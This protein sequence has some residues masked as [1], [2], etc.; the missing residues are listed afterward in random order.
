MTVQSKKI[1]KKFCFKISLVYYASILFAN[2]M[3]MFIPMATVTF[4]TVNE[5]SMIKWIAFTDEN[6]WLINFIT[7]LCFVIPSGIC[8]KD[9]FSILFAKKDD[10][11]AKK[12]INLPLRFS[13]LGAF[14][15][16]LTF[17]AELIVLFYV[18]HVLSIKIFYIIVN[19]LLFLAL[20]GIFS[21]IVS[22]L[23]LATV[24][25]ATVLPKLF[26]KGEV[27]KIPGVKNL[28]LT[29]MFVVLYISICF[30]PIVYLL[31]AYISEHLNYGIKITSDTIVMSFVLLF[32]GLALTVV[33]MKLFTIPLKKLT[34]QT[35]EI[36]KGNYDYRVNISSNDEMGV[37]S[38][39]FNDMTESIK[40]KE[41]M[42]STFGK[43]VDPN[44]LYNVMNFHP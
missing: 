32:S 2:L 18:K 9:C 1:N 24:N 26:P 16:I 42:R 39:A 31:I 27:T 37:L 25:R 8:L 13:F 34:I 11:I 7:V 17:F 29:L 19:S 4:P 36:K 43:I 20:E 23:V 10:E 6:Q 28:S 15:W 35:K 30:F 44:V 38:D 21:F 40:E 3:I 22:Y 12:I 33:F 5:D 41:F 14:G